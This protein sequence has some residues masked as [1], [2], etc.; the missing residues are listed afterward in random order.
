MNIRGLASLR[1][2]RILWK[3]RS[4]KSYSLLIFWLYR[5]FLLTEN[6]VES[7]KQYVTY[8]NLQ[9]SLAISSIRYLKF[10]A[11]SKFFP[12][13]FSIYDLLP[14]KMSRYLELHYLELFAISN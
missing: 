5:F 6:R 13:P 11:I 1:K 7:V 8:L 12:G 9:S 4:V 2:E 10:R 3:S 14:Y